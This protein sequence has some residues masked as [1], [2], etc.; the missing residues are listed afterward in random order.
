V[1][2]GFALVLFFV[3]AG[4]STSRATLVS[5]EE[6]HAAIPP[7]AA[8]PQPLSSGDPP[9][10]GPFYEPEPQG[11]PTEI[12]RADA[13]NVHYAELDRATCL[14]E[15]GR[16]GIAF[17]HAPDTAGVAT[18]LWLRGPLHG[19]ALH[20]QLAPSQR[21]HSSVEIFD[22]RLLL[23]FDDFAAMLAQ[24]D[25]VEV[26]HMSAYRPRNA[27]G[28]TPKYVGKQHCA[29]LAVDVGSFKKKDGTTLDVLRDFH[30]RVGVPTCG[31]GGKPNPPGAASDTLWSFV[32]DA[33]ERA[34]F[35]VILTPN[36]NQQH[37]NHFHFEITPNAAWMLIH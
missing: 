14:A 37:K 17:A 30:G 4:C 13:P 5:S 24:R 28:C 1:R 8:P 3:A 7:D 6:G 16:R 11:R 12:L 2:S 29:A 21:E 18:P 10:T 23:A 27:G 26:I 33:A 32:C 22:C 36:F 34:T 35:H 19:V 15:L 9:P 20:S 31:R 25:V